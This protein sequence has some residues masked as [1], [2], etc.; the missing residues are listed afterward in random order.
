M[1]FVWTSLLWISAINLRAGEEAEP[2][3]HNEAQPRSRLDWHHL[4]SDHMK[5]AVGGVDFS[6]V[7][8][9]LTPLEVYLAPSHVPAFICSPCRWVLI[10]L[11]FFFFFISHTLCA[12]SSSCPNDL[13]ICSSLCSLAFAPCRSRGFLP[14]GL[15]LSQLPFS[16][17][18]Y[19]STNLHI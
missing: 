14:T 7:Q 3:A 1:L 19:L 9:H 11:S 2:V 10:F 12:I 13:I 4:S 5:V 15:V 8:H 6:S 18:F 17:M 16:L